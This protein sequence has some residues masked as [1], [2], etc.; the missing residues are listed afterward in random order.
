MRIAVARVSLVLGAHVPVQTL[1]PLPG[2]VMDW[3]VQRVIVIQ[4]PAARSIAGLSRPTTGIRQGVILQNFQSDGIRL[5]AS[6]PGSI[7]VAAEGW[8]ACPGIVVG[9][10]SANSTAWCC[11]IPGAGGAVCNAV[12]VRVCNGAGCSGQRNLTSAIR[13]KHT[14]R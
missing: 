4:E 1:V 3:I 11:G 2:V 13:F 12:G 10:G 14:D 5:R 7:E 9:G 8:I 6:D